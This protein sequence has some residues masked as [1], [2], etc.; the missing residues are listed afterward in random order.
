MY[1]DIGDPIFIEGIVIL[2][3]DILNG[4]VLE[5]GLGQHGNEEMTELQTKA[6]VGWAVLVLMKDSSYWCFCVLPRRKGERCL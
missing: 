1:K 4:M 5:T 2:I 3:D 6:G